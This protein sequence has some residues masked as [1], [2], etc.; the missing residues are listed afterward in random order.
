MRAVEP[1]TPVTRPRW[2]TVLLVAAVV[3][4]LDIATKLTVVA[5][6]TG[7]PPLRLLGGLLMLREDRNSGAAF[8]IGPS[9]TLVYAVIAICVI[10]VIARAARRIGSLPWALALGLILGGAMGNLTDRMFRYPGPLRGWVVDWIQLPHWPVF[11][12]ADSAIVC[13]AVLSALLAVR[14]TR[15][16]GAPPPAQSTEKSTPCASGSRPE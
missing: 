8:S 13:G 7:R 16:D 14:G 12:I 5:T 6:L 2:R 10:V 15:L 4:A 9:L 11:N 3:L 1:R